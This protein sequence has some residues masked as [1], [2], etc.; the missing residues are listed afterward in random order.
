MGFKD[1]GKLFTKICEGEILLFVLHIYKFLGPFKQMNI[2]SISVENVI[3]FQP[4]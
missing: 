4:K 3:L 1:F 2:V